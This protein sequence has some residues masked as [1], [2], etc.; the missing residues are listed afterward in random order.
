MPSPHPVCNQRRSR[1]PLFRRQLYVYWKW[2][3]CARLD[4][5]VCHEVDDVANRVSVIAEAVRNFLHG[6]AHLVLFTNGQ[7]SI[8]MQLFTHA[9]SITHAV[10]RRASVWPLLEIA[11]PL[12][13]LHSSRARPLCARKADT[14]RHRAKAFHEFAVRRKVIHIYKDK[15][16]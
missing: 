8:S 6:V 16:K 3:S 13:V 1:R 9:I 2:W 7:Y 11:R 4:A 10:H 5:L 12:P 15:N 14:P